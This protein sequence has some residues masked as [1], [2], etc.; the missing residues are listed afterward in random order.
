MHILYMC[1]KRL[2]S[3]IRFEASCQQTFQ[4]SPITRLDTNARLVSVS[5]YRYLTLKQDQYC[6]LR[7]R[8]KF[9]PLQGFE[10]GTTWFRVKCANH[11]TTK[12]VIN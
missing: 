8:K 4:K 1:I 6:Y 9:K 10:P 5:T 12:T 11:Y 2:I 3:K 7:T